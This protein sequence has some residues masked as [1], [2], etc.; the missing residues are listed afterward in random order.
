MGNE[1]VSCWWLTPAHDHQKLTITIEI[2]T[3]IVSM[4]SVVASFFSQFFFMFRLKSPEVMF[5]ENKTRG[6][7]NVNGVARVRD[8]FTFAF[9]LV[10]S[11]FINWFADGRTLRRSTLSCI[12]EIVSCGSSVL[13]FFV[14]FLLLLI[15]FRC[16]GGARSKWASEANEKEIVSHGGGHAMAKAQS[17]IVFVFAI[18]EIVHGICGT[19]ATALVRHSTNLSLKFTL[20]VARHRLGIEE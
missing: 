2:W 17:T 6:K 3:E 8:N 9:F 16:F 12:I 18:V 20:A 5:G 19:W 7:I 4:S 15:K 11:R 1:K 14:H 13:F 10:F